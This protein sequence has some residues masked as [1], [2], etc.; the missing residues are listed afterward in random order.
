MK[1]SAAAV[2]SIIG[3]VFADVSFE[4]FERGSSTP[5]SGLSSGGITPDL[6]SISPDSE[7]DTMKNLLSALHN[8]SGSS[9]E[10]VQEQATK[11]SGGSGDV[12]SAP[13]VEVKEEEKIEEQPPRERSNTLPSAE[14]TPV[15]EVAGGVMLRV[16]TGPKQSPEKRKS[17][18]P[19]VPEKPTTFV[20]PEKL[21]FHEK[22]ALHKKVADSN[23]AP[24]AP[25]TPTRPKSGSDAS[26]QQR[27]LST[28]VIAEEPES[29]LKR[30][31]SEGEME[32]EATVE[33]TSPVRLSERIA[34]FQASQTK[35]GMAPV[36]IHPRRMSEEQRLA[37]RTGSTSDDS[38][39]ASTSDLHVNRDSTPTYVLESGPSDPY[40]SDSQDTSGAIAASASGDH[41]QPLVSVTI[42]TNSN[43]NN[44]SGKFVTTTSLYVAAVPSDVSSPRDDEGDERA[45]KHGVEERGE[46]TAQ[47]KQD[48]TDRVDVLHNAANSTLSDSDTN[49]STNNS[50]SIANPTPNVQPSDLL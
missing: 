20:S 24:V 4:E 50:C 44:D 17:A 45:S 5:R 41:E 3:E 11:A 37:R 43:N 31:F 27:P 35:A 9:E 14:P 10:P 23:A 19:K 30:T 13:V 47:E 2:K 6:R 29:T 16:P 21:S 7:P 49:E 40:I 36:E 34:S 8:I 28:I 25:S 1:A 12:Y 18:P 39:V 48:G 42:N 26:R 38:E 22:L 33:V 46:T 32:S 15:E